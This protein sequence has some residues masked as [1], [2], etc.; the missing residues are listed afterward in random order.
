MLRW[1]AEQVEL[2]CDEVAVARTSTPLEIA[3]ALVKL[4]RRA[5]AVAGYS[6][7]T[8]PASS[9]FV[10]VDAPGLQ[11]RVRRLISFSDVPPSRARRRP[12]ANP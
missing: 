8:A 7:D 9:G 12:D 5:L 1:R 4:R 2:V 3:G 6:P 10:G 11:R